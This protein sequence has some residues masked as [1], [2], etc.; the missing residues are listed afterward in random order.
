MFKNSILECAD[1]SGAVFVKITQVYAR[2]NNSLGVRTS[3]VMRQFDR[4]K[5]LQKK[6]KYACLIL[7]SRQAIRR[8]NGLC[9]K[10]SQNRG[11]LFS[12]RDFDK[13]LGTRVFGPA[14]REIRRKGLETSIL[15]KLS[16]NC[17]FL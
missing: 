1:N 16:S 17:M 3:V 5:K 8:K 7:T 11:I 15:H 14:G 9:V 6:K 2:R 13:L 10:F 4:T 12:D